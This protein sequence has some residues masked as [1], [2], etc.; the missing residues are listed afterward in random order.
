MVKSRRV[1]LVLILSGILIALSAAPWIFRFPAHTP[2]LPVAQAASEPLPDLG[3]VPPFALTAEDGKKWSSKELEGKVWV[4][5]FFL[6]SCQ[7]ACPVMAQNMWGIHEYFKGNDRVRFVSISVDPGT[8]TPDM[9][10]D[11]AKK[12][13][14]DTARW[15]FLTGP[16]EEVHR[17]ASEQGLKVGV[18]ETPMQHS[19]R[20]ILVDA[21]GHI[22]GYY[23]GMEEMS[24]RQCIADIER[25]LK[26]QA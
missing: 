22:R 23:E 25:L 15:R 3:P 13:Q 7:G 16:V 19:R 10:A 4:A 20:F 12:Y 5:D 17:M 2:A 6:T 14:A 8:D 26:E 21:R 24:A 11:Y 9:L 1:G 18:P